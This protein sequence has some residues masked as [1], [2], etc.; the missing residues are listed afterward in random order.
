[1]RD[2]SKDDLT[3]RRVLVIEDE[4]MVA[5]LLE[6]TL[7][8]MGCEIVGMAS[9]YKD[10]AAKAASLSFDVAVLDIN[11]NGEH[12]V[13]IAEMLAER[14]TAFVIATGY[15]AANLPR[16][17][18]EVPVLQKPFHVQDLKRAICEALASR[19]ST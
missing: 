16:S 11:L 9:R 8:D 17:L 15:G 6:D 10:A 3:G 19:S 5:M 18:Q 1:M 12:T 7:T 13:P 2:A 14:G 4:S